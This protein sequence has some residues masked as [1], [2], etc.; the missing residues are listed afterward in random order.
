MSKQKAVEVGASALER[1]SLV[2]AKKSVPCGRKVCP[3]EIKHRSY[4]EVVKANTNNHNTKFKPRDCTTNFPACD[5]IIPNAN[6]T[7]TD[8]KS[9]SNARDIVHNNVH[10]LAENKGNEKYCKDN[11]RGNYK[12]AHSQEC[13]IKPSSNASW[14]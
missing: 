8:T 10:H 11:D 13:K 4:A 12:G 6:T 5:Q 1:T 2:Q 7:V 9:N 3:G 14:K